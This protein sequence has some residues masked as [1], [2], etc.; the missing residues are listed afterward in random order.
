MAM[1]IKAAILIRRPCDDSL[2]VKAY[3]T[4]IIILFAFIEVAVDIQVDFDNII[5][6]KIPKAYQHQM[7]G[8]SA[9]VILRH[10]RL[11]I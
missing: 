8:Y 7:F 9:P 3:K 2:G 1:K 6:I 11:H 4:F 5:D 10:Y